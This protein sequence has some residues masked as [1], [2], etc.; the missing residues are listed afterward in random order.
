MDSMWMAVWQLV[1]NCVRVAD[2]EI[3]PEGATA[4]AQAL[5]RNSTL[6]RLALGSAS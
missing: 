2:T 6:R 5:A 3:G 4:V 1:D